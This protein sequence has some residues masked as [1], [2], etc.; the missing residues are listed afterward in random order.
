MTGE[1]EPTE[2][3]TEESIKSWDLRWLY[4]FAIDKFFLLE[5][6]F[7]LCV[8]GVISTFFFTSN[9]PSNSE[10]KAKKLTSGSDSIRFL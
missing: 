4:N 10:L 3:S 5:M 7:F 2:G 1:E 8:F 9:E 6:I